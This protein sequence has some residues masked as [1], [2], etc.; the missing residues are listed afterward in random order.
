LGFDF[1]RVAPLRARAVLGGEAV[2]TAAVGPVVAAA[3]GW[4]AL[5]F[6]PDR[7][8]F[9]AS[10]AYP[11]FLRNALDH[12]AP[13][14]AA[15]LPEFYAIGEA[16]PMQGHAKVGDATV[17]VGPRLVGPPGFWR[18]ADAT[19]AVDFLAR[20]LDLAPPEEPSDPLPDV[21]EPGRP[22]EPLAPH[23]AAGAIVLL[24]LAWWAFWRSP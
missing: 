11:L 10:P 21:G 24:L 23:L 3:P 22:A 4:V 12:L 17:R 5:G 8:L 6:D 15:E 20:D 19:I 18:F 9:A 2:A 14:A 13:R 7:A 1:T 16:S